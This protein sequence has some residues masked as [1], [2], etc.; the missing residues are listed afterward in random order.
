MF[1][2]VLIAVAVSTS[3]VAASVADSGTIRL[4]RVVAPAA[5]QVSYYRQLV[6]AMAYQGERCQQPTRPHYEYRPQASVVRQAANT[7]AYEIRREV[8]VTVRR[9]VRHW[10]F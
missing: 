5:P 2:K 6:P 1:R 3:L 10:H 8:V 4:G 9:G 7:A